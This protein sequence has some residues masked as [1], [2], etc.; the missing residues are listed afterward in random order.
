MAPAAILDLSQVKSYAKTASGTPFWVSVSNLVQIYALAAE[1]LR[2]RQKFKMGA[3][4]HIG[5]LV[6]TLGHPRRSL[7][8]RK[9]VLKF[10]GNRVNAF[11]VIV[12]WKFRK[13]GLKRLFPPPKFSFLGVLTS[14][15]IVTIVSF[16]FFTS[17]Y[18]SMSST[19]FPCNLIINSLVY[20]RISLQTTNAIKKSPCVIWW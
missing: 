20:D 17:V 13:F 7:G 9:S 3:V 4:R 5:L 1:L 2:F 12:I 10:H 14:L 18:A 6:A 16:T 8:D 11:E 19:Y 15:Q